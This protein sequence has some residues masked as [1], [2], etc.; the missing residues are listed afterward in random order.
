MDAVINDLSWY[1][2]ERIDDSDHNTT[3]SVQGDNGVVTNPDSVVGHSD[4][5]TFQVDE[6]THDTPT[7]TAYVTNMSVDV[8]LPGYLPAWDFS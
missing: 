6:S 1:T 2:H 4:S 5:T 7:K 3:L 8:P